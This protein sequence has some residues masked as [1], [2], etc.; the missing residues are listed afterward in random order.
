MAKGTMQAMPCL[1]EDDREFDP[2]VI[3]KRATQHYRELFGNDGADDEEPRAVGESINTEC[4]AWEDEEDPSSVYINDETVSAAA[5]QALRPG[6]T[7]G[8]DGL[9]SEAWMRPWRGASTSASPT[10]DRRRAHVRHV[11]LVER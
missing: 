11:S 2:I 8:S 5:L 10:T 9:P 4:N 6:R 3:G 1:Q 7:C